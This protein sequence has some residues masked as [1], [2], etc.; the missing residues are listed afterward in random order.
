MKKFIIFYAAK[1]AKQTIQNLI[2]G[3]VNSQTWGTPS[4]QK[5]GDN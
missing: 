5:W 3:G 1:K 4:T 2:W